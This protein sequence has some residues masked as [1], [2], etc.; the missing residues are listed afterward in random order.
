MKANKIKLGLISFTA[1]VFATLSIP[2]FAYAKSAQALDNG[3]GSDTSQ[4]GSSGDS[5]NGTQTGKLEDK[6]LEA[7][8][9]RQQVITATMARVQDRAQKQ[10]QVFDKVAERVQN[11]YE[12]KGYHI[13]DYGQLVEQMTA[14]RTAAMNATSTMAQNGA[15]NCGG[16]A[17]KGT[18]D[19]FNTQAK[20]ANATLKDYKTAV[21]N[22]ISA[23]S[24]AATEVTE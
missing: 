12:D 17:P 19:G 7:C 3:S 2:L 16:D 1:L 20:A 4:N 8:E 5:S 18:L 9:K 24:T 23:V 15:F 13:A 21:S 14:T 22:L 10:L 6:K 11:F